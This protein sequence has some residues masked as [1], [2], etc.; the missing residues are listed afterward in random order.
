M[1]KK[2]GFRLL[3]TAILVALAISL[4]VTVAGVYADGDEDKTKEMDQGQDQALPLPDKVELKY[5]NLGSHLDGLVVEVEEEETTSE[6]AASDTPVHSGESVAVTIHLSGSVDEVAAFLEDNG[7]DPRNVGEDYIEAY[8]PVTLLGQLSEQP[9]VIRVREIIP[10]E[11]DYGPITSQGVQAHFSAAWNQ[12]GYTGQGIK[13]GI[14]DAHLAFNGFRDLMGTELPYTV[15]ARCYTDIGRFTQDLADCEDA[16]EG[17]N[18][19]TLVAEAVVDIAPEVSLYI[20]TP[21][22]RGDHRNVVDWMVSEGVKVIVWAESSIFD[23]PGDGTS[24]FSDSPLRT[25]DRAVAGGVVW[26]NSA[27][28]HARRTWFARAPFRDSDGDRFIEFAV[29]DE[30]N[31]ITLEAGDRIVV[32]LRWDDSWGGA[33]TNLDLGIQDNV[34]GRFLTGSIDPQSGA[35]GHIPMEFI[36]GN[37]LRS[38]EYGVVVE[39]VSGSVPDWIQLTVWDV[40]SIQHYTKNGSIG[41]PAES[42]NPGMLAV[43]AAHWNDVRAIELYSSR[44]PTPDGRF[45]PDIVGADCGATALRPLNEYNE[46]FCGTSQAAPHVAGLA[47]LVRQRFPGYTPA[48]VAG[49]LKDNAEQRQSPDPNNTWG[50]GFAE[51]PP[52]DGTV[53]PVPTPSNAFTRNPAADFNTLA[54]A[55]NGAPGGIWSDGTTMWVADWIDDKIYAYDLATKSRVPGRDFDTLAA[56][57]EIWPGLI[58]S[59]GTTMYVAYGIGGKIY[60]YDL[61]T[62]VRVPSKDFDTLNTAGNSAPSGIWSDRT[63]MWV[64]DW[65]DGKIYAYDLATKARVPGKDFDTLKSNRNLDPEGIWSNGTTMWVADAHNQK[66]YAYDMATRARAPGREF[67]TLEAAGIE[68]LRGIWSDGTTMWVADWI[69]NKIY[70]YRMPQ[71]VSTAHLEVSPATAVPNQAVTVTGRG[72]TSGATI[73]AANDGSEVTLGGDNEALTRSA[74]GFRNFN[75]GEAVTVDSGGSWSATIIVPITAATTTPGAHPLKITDSGNRSGSVDITI[76]ERTLTIEPAEARPGEWVTLTGSGFPS[77]N[78]RSKEQ[79]TPSVSIMYADDDVGTARP[80]SSGTISLRFVV[81]RDATIP[82]T[83]LVEAVYTIPGTSTLVRASTNHE[84]PGAR[85]R[86]SMDEG[87]PGDSVTVTGDGFKASSLVE[88]VRIGGTEVTPAP[89]PVTDRN[90]E[91]TATILVPD[92]ANGTHAVNVSVS[93]VTASAN[94]TVSTPRVG[95][96]ASAA[97][98]FSPAT[99]APGGRVTVTI[100]AAN[101]GLAGGVTETLPAG[102]SYVSSTH[103]SNQVIHPVEGNSQ[104]VRFTLQG[105]TSLTYTV[106]ASSVEGSYTFSGTLRDSD[107][108]DHTVGG[109]SM[110]TVSSGD[111]LVARYDANGNGTIEKSEVIAAI[112]DYLFGTGADAPTKA[113]VIRLINLYLFGPGG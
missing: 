108:N 110:V 9:G 30:V 65:I 100:T 64:A 20:A 34:T 52:P 55:G 98:S 16:D 86:L 87:K 113:E 78:G 28:N 72:F 105:E 17:G 27:G 41:N 25:V 48:Q 85:I 36:A 51:L 59:D 76:P 38:S 106:T 22:S 91:F 31:D 92:L 37:V 49:Y 66:I 67:N 93:G 58:W 3:M 29:G 107:R 62:K 7:G 19:G 11:P 24:P 83:N 60:A 97:R 56:A 88:Y 102:L 95:V 68:E 80:D 2:A 82:S 44:G 26:V 40:G 35:A 103:A 101:Y 77:D 33:S 46:G 32:Q 15:Q 57:G 69:D 70:A 1:S 10:P 53:L 13:V 104:M 43:G 21:P 112:N 99:V 79:S 75:N 42:A 73:N 109:A 94:F 74:G 8:V 47:A 14:I 54:D 45:K 5:P 89:R 6:D 63:T 4:G 23:G 61:A 84:V 90:G 39:H 71:A 81:P 96:T 111:P 12:A 50:H 18:H